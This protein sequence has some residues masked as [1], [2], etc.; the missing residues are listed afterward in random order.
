MS[1]T[2]HYKSNLRDIFFNLFEVQDIGT[3]SLGKGPFKGMDED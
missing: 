3:T 2:D 1:I